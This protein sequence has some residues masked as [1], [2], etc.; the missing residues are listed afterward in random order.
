VRDRQKF[1]G[2][3]LETD[4]R[5]PGPDPF[6]MWRTAFSLGLWVSAQGGRSPSYWAG[7]LREVLETIPGLRVRIEHLARPEV[8][9]GVDDPAFQAVLSLAYFPDV[10]VNIDGLWAVSKAVAPYDDVWPFAE[11]VLAAFGSKR[12]MWG[13]DFPYVLEYQSY[14]ETCEEMRNRLASFPASVSEDVFQDTPQRFCRPSTVSC[15]SG[16]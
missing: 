8:T 1:S 14:A 2:I 6:L 5:S 9:L 12:V 11:A 16:D 4:A 15:E 13:S 10:V 3:R 7:P